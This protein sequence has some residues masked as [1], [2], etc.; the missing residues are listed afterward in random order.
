MNW[1]CRN[2]FQSIRTRAIELIDAYEEAIAM[3]KDSTGEAESAM[4]ALTATSWA[5]AATTRPRLAR[6]ASKLDATPSPY[7]S[8]NRGRTGRGTAPFPA[9]QT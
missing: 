2:N 9:C 3:I 7:P 1:P 8:R 5:L 4:R 6:P